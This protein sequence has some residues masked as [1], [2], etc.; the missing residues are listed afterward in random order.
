MLQGA[1]RTRLILV[2]APPGSGKST[3]VAQWRAAAA[4]GRS[5]AWLTLD[6]SLDEAAALWQA[7]AAALRASVPGL[8][9]SLRRLPRSRKEPALPHLLN[10][11]AGLEDSVVLTLDD[12]HSLED[13]GCLEQV[14]AFIDHLPP[15]T[16]VVLITRAEPEL[17]LP[18]YRA[19]DDLLELG[20]ADLAWSREEAAV[21]IR[22]LAGIRLRD[23]DLDAL[24]GVT[25]GWTIALRLASLSL[26]SA[27]DPAAAVAAFN[28]S[29]RVVAD[30]LWDEVLGMVSPTVRRFLCRVSVLDRFTAPLCDA[31]AGT[32]NAAELLPVL[33]RSNLFL[34]PLDD[35]RRWYRLH[36]LL[37]QALQEGLVNT[38]P[39]LVTEL[40]QRASDWYAHNDLIQEAGAHGL[41]GGGNERV[42]GLFKTHWMDYV[43][44]GQLR[45][46]R[47]WLASAGAATGH[48]PALAVC[49]AWVAALSGDRVATRHRLRVALDLDHQGALPDGSPSV[50]FAADLIQG[51]FGFDGVPDMLDAARAACDTEAD[52]TTRWYSAARAALAYTLYLM[53]D[54]KAA[55]QP[56]REAAQSTAAWPPLQIM[57]LSVLSLALGDLGQVAEVAEPARAAHELLEASGLDATPHAALPAGALG[58]VLAAEGRYPEGR[59]LMERV[60]SVC[61]KAIG[62][63]GWPTLNLLIVLAETSV[64]AGEW[65]AAD[66]FIV[67]ARHVLA[68]EQDCGEY[69]RARLAHI[70]AHLVNQRP[71]EPANGA[72]TGHALTAREQ[73]VLRLLVEDLSLREIGQ[74]MF[75]STNTVKTHTR[76]IYR[77]LGVTSRE[78]AVQIARHLRLV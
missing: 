43:S 8:K 20:M 3:L 12:F 13:P 52:P 78:E 46:L 5:F 49:G 67:Q 47:D 76:S 58:S 34:I 63:S 64:D 30:Y 61:K 27:Y 37:Q 26:R 4:N 73:S 57:A 65:E 17:P 1:R 18:R 19:T 39:G 9:D 22:R 35:H 16:Q 38:E 44:T 62:V 32:T 33:D 28:G 25:E 24:L 77:K 2:S 45:A 7:V 42:T 54:A 71:A 70:H 29:H 56:A 59:Q 36:P 69:L 21:L 50:R 41:A 75:V 53:G 48:D 51:L 40:H 55:I 66:G 14:G 15:T 72:A 60:L 23:T 74:Q 10:A 31:V 68:T 6:K 11:L